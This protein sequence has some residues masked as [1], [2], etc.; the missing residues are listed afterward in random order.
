[1][2][3]T[4]R[5]SAPRYRCAARCGE[6]PSKN[7][8]TRTSVFIVDDVHGEMEVLV[9]D[10]PLPLRR[11]RNISATGL[12]ASGQL[13]LILRPSDL[14]VSLRSGAMEATQ[15]ANDTRPARVLVVD[16]SITTRTMERNLF[17]AAGY[18]VLVAAD[19]LEAWNILQVE[20]RC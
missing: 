3:P 5:F 10:L 17:E 7:T 16:D 19:G 9:K 20:R 8:A 13:A 4:R 1:M 12:L 14:L 2:P 18:D 15:E 11:V 6:S